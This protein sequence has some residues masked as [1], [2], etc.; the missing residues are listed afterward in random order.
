MSKRLI[1]YEAKIFE[2]TSSD[3]DRYALKHDGLRRYLASSEELS[4][5]KRAL[6]LLAG[7][8]SVNGLWRS[9]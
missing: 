6:K 4:V 8:H 5:A 3:M 2:R 9:G 1:E 7:L